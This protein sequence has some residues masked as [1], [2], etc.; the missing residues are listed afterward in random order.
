MKKFW[1]HSHALHVIKN[2]LKIDSTEKFLVFSKIMSFNRSNVFFYQSKI[3]HFQNMTF[4]M[5][6]LI[7]DQFSTDQIGKFSIFKFL[8]K[9]FFHASFMFRIHMHCIVFYIHFVILQ[10][11]LSLFSYITCIHFA[12]LGTQLDLKIDWFINF[13][14]MY[15]L[16]YAIF[17]CELQKIFFLRDLIDNQCANIFS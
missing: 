2:I 16:V 8:T 4:C 9:F 14:V 5:T 13:W 6:Q 17:M 7:L 3:L 11:F 10:S 12:K 1:N 15:V